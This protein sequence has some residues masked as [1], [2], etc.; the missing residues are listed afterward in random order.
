MSLMSDY[1]NRFQSQAK[2][3]QVDEEDQEEST[4]SSEKAEENGD[5]HNDEENV[6]QNA[7]V[8][9]GAIVFCD[10]SHLKKKNV[11]WGLIFKYKY[12]KTNASY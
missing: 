4:E 6:N 8:S 1:S 11:Y 2:E 5:S 3:D 9:I 10:F 12:H 7:V